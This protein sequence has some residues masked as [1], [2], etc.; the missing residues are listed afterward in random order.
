MERILTKVNMFKKSKTKG[1]I[2]VR[3]G[4]SDVREYFAR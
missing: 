3:I 1:S 4:S 2:K